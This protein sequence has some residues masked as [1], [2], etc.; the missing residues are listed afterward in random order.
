MPKWD[1]SINLPLNE[2]T[3]SANDLVEDSTIFDIR[4]E[5]SLIMVDISDEIE[6]QTINESDLSVAGV[7][8]MTSMSIDTIKIDS[9]DLLNVPDSVLTMGNIAPDLYDFI[10]DTIPIPGVSPEIDPVKLISGDF[11]SVHV[12]SGTVQLKIVN[13]LPVTIASNTKIRIYSHPRIAGDDSLVAL[14]PINENILPGGNITKSS[15]FQDKWLISPVSIHFEL[16]TLDSEEDVEITQDMLDNAGIGISLRFLNISADQA[17][18]RLSAHEYTWEEA[19]AIKEDSNKIYTGRIKTGQ[20]HLEID[21]DLPLMGEVTISIFNFLMDDGSYFEHTIYIDS[22]S[23]EIPNDIILNDIRIVKID[24][25]GFPNLNPDTP[26]DSIHYKIDLSHEKMDNPITMS[27]GD[28]VGIKIEMDSL[29][30]QMLKGDIARTEIEIEP[31]ETTN[32]SDYEGFDGD[33]DFRNLRLIFNLNND[34][35][36]GTIQFTLNLRGYREEN[37][38]IIDSVIMV[39]MISDSI[40]PGQNQFIIGDPEIDPENS[41]KISDLIN[42]MPT[43]IIVDGHASIEGRVT[44]ELGQGISGDYAF[45]APFEIKLT[46][47]LTLESDDNILTR[48]DITRDLAEIIEE[49]RIKHLELYSN[50]VNELPLGGKLL[51]CFSDDTTITDLFDTTNVPLFIVMDHFSAADV[52]ENGIV[53]SPYLSENYKIIAPE[54]LNVFDNPPVK[55]GYKVIINPTDSQQNDGYVKLQSFN[56]ATVKGNLSFKFRIDNDLFDK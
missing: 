2:F 43:K 48:G 26:I 12:V 5:D 44:I 56:S 32:I 31:I 55:W 14:I 45:S 38:Q 30:F 22:N 37:G 19:I 15:L 25:D 51:I 6:R 18:S 16:H 11:D 9:F 20:L 46:Q 8:S 47:P 13:N 3:F 33:I 42:M 36:E 28:S 27:A 34:F 24:P 50:I 39:P 53:N 10:D 35:E 49:E 52:D 54:N 29:Y 17:T 1:S 4:A 23:Y 40:Q 7:D 41:E 21:N